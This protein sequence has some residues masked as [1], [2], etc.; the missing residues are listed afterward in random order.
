MAEDI[1]NPLNNPGAE[2]ISPAPQASAPR[3]EPPEPN[4]ELDSFLDEVFE[5]HSAA[6]DTEPAT[7]EPPPVQAGRPPEDRAPAAVP[8]QQPARDAT[9]REPSA[10]PALASDAPAPTP[11]PENDLQRQTLEL[12][13]EQLRRMGQQPEPER[14]QPQP[15]T[16][17]E[18][19]RQLQPRV[20]QYIEA[21]WITEDHALLYPRETALQVHMWDQIQQGTQQLQQTREFTETEQQRRSYEAA[22]RQ[23]NT[24]ID[25]VAARGDVFGALGDAEVRQGFREFLINE[26]NPR[27]SQ[28]NADFLARQFYAYN[29]QLI[30]DLANQQRESG[31]GQQEAPSAAQLASQEGSSARGSQVTREKPEFADM[32]EGMAAARWYE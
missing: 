27:L 4:D 12:L 31:N 2:P 32:L 3:E 17:D 19:V 22:D 14:P 16:P 20:Q 7:E 23:I 6:D 25:E 29:H 13:N 26:V 15:I 28:V 30:F 21:G 10:Q 18:L 24:A 9:P 1:H 5:T 11:Q 8:T